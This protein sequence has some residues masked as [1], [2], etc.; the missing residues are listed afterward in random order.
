MLSLERICDS[1]VQVFPLT[2]WI[3]A[4]HVNHLHIHRPETYIFA[5]IQP[6]DDVALPAAI[7]VLSTF[8]FEDVHEIAWHSHDI[9]RQSTGG[10]LI[11]N[12]CIHCLPFPILF[13]ACAR[14]VYMAHPN[15]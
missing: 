13:L 1:S 11:Q 9:A 12:T 10:G 6:D 2:F 7:W 15:L 5:H 14:D 3:N 8:V 4:H